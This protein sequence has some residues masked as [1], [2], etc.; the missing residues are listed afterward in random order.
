MHHW[1][2]QTVPEGEFRSTGALQ[3]KPDLD[4][5]AAPEPYSISPRQLREGQ[6]VHED[7][8]RDENNVGPESPSQVPSDASHSRWVERVVREV[9]P[10]VARRFD[11][12]AKWFREQGIEPLFG[13][14]WNLCINATFPKQPRIHC[15]PHVDRKNIVGICALLVYVLPSCRASLPFFFRS[16]RH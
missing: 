5:P 2:L 7:S 15:D 11:E 9:F 12:S 3:W 1:A 10:G 8:C 4:P 13:V 6:V 16:L 14:Y